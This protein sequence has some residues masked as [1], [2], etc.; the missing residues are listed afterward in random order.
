MMN[1]EQRVRL[2]RACAHDDFNHRYYE[3]NYT[4]MRR[5]VESKLSSIEVN[6]EV[7][8]FLGTARIGKTRILENLDLEF[9]KARQDERGRKKD[10]V[11]VRVP[12]GGTA[13]AILSAILRAMGEPY[14]ST[15][16]IDDMRNRV[17]QRF[18]TTEIKVALFD[19]I[20]HTVDE[21][22]KTAV[23]AASDF[24]KG[25]I[26]DNPQVS[27]VFAGIPIASKLR[28]QNSQLRGRCDKPVYFLPYCW[29]IDD[30]HKA[31]YQ[32][33]ITVYQAVVET[34]QEKTLDVKHFAEACYLLSGGC[35]GFIISFIRSLANALEQ[36]PKAE[37]VELRHLISVYEKNSRE[38]EFPYN[39][40]ESM[41][42][43]PREMLVQA[44]AWVMQEHG[45]K[46]FMNIESVLG[47]VHE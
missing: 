29:G 7:Q 5:L 10:L 37:Y 40:F 19:E 14:Q 31:F 32:V 28:E 47:V 42:D 23:R 22:R 43:I 38:I 9:G 34:M 2:L 27:F 11:Y 1:K 33:A 20:Q 44:W 6:R 4:M 21:G 8:M 39:P 18:L 46:R 26:E 35:F 41:N 13:G 16:K 3:H 25:L 15:T 45:L 12:E 30:E 24:L 17:R 36:D